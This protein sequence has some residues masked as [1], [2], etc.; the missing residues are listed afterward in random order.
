MKIFLNRLPLVSSFFPSTS[1]LLGP[2]SCWRGDDCDL[3]ERELDLGELPVAGPELPAGEG[4]SSR[5]NQWFAH[6]SS[7]QEPSCSSYCLLLT[8]VNNFNCK[9]P[10]Q[11][12]FSMALAPDF[13][14]E[15]EG[16]IAGQLWP[17]RS[18]NDVILCSASGRRC[19]AWG[20]GPSGFLWSSQ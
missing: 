12:T 1:S 3:D 20:P 8:C 17:T 6:L 5:T 15:E 16:D 10:P 11:V 2:L 13:A 4:I 19:G 18:C 14:E 7:Q 9:A